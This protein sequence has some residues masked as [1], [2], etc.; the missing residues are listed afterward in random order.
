LHHCAVRVI[1][2]PVFLL[3][4]I[5]LWFSEPANVVLVF[6][7]LGTALLWLRWRRTGRYVV[8][9]TVVVMILIGA[10]PIGSWLTT[11][12][13]NR[14]PTIHRVDGPVDGIIVLGG[15]FNTYI[16]E[17]RG[18]VAISEP[19]E[20]LT[21]FMALGR[22]F[23][24]AKLVFS[25]GSASFLRPDL[26]EAIL[27]RRF[28]AEM[29]FDADRVIYESES[30]STYENAVFSFNLVHPAKGERW[31]LVTSANHMARAVGC[32]RKLGWEVTPFPVDYHTSGD[33]RLDWS[34]DFGAGIGMLNGAAY[35][36]FGLIT[37]YLVGRTS[38]LFPA[39]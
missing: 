28:F 7:V 34:F 22:R 20:R 4:K 24:A 30:R 37:Y 32:F 18:Q 5:F 12:L 23:P 6:L 13:E 14:F 17:K 15:S 31:L 29:G 36:W 27:A 10:L 33:T 9:A 19:V 3:G 26:K 39:P 35:E 1:N 8:T 2:P 25:G 21:E 11:I 38:A 16:T